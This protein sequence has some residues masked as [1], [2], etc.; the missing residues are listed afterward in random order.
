[1]R[2]A[3]SG[4]RGLNYYDGAVRS[5]N[6]IGSNRLR[7]D[8][9]SNQHCDRVDAR[10]RNR[11]QPLAMTL[12]GY[13]AVYGFVDVAS[14][15]LGAAIKGLGKTAIILIATAFS[16]IATVSLAQ[17]FASGAEVSATYWWT[18]LIV[19]ATLQ[20]LILAAAAFRMLHLV[21]PT[22]IEPTTL[23]EQDQPQ[24]GHVTVGMI[25]QGES[26]AALPRPSE[27]TG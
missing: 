3:A 16:G 20:S 7:V 21:S 10:K 9:I 2:C 22:R 14:L 17:T 6:R 5:G 23:N 27:V 15:I 12:L 19:W 26:A 18:T 8:W 11:Y 4:P 1:M 13:A 24:C 25:D